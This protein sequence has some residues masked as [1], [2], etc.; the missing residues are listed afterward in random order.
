VEPI[1]DLLLVKHFMTFLHAGEAEAV[2]LALEKKARLVLIDDRDGRAAAAESDLKICG[3]IGILIK[4]KAAG[5]I[6]N[7]S[8]ALDDLR[9]QYVFWV[10]DGIYHEALRLAGE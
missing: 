3:T 9:S 8:S 10:S 4:A 5:L 7:V 2:V 6:S 1:R